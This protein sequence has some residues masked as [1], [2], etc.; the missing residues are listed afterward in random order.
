[1]A[2]DNLAGYFA[3][4][5]SCDKE[6][7]SSSCELYIAWFTE[8][9]GGVETISFK[10]DHKGGGEEFSLLFSY[11]GDVAATKVSLRSK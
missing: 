9:N 6:R 10:A 4:P 5:P 8:V 11:G 1:M 3:I 7:G 2:S